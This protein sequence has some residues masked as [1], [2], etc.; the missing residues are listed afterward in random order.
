MERKKLRKKLQRHGSSSST[1]TSRNQLG[2]PHIIGLPTLE[3]RI[4]SAPTSAEVA[5]AAA[6]APLASTAYA[7][8]LAAAAAA[9]AAA[10]DAAARG[11]VDMVLGGGL[12]QAPRAPQ[13]QRVRVRGRLTLTLTLT[14]TQTQTQTLTQP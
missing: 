14:Q 6:A 10:K 7:A 5:A 9:A 12:P 8:A 3:P 11:V 1:H 4:R 13:G 2:L